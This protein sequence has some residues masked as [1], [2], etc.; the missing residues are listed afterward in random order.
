M[1]SETRNS[2]L[3]GI[4]ENAGIA[5]GIGIFLLITGVLALGAPLV[6]GISIMLMI[7]LLMIVGGVAQCILAFKVGAFGRGVLL[8]LMGVLMVVVGGYMLSQPVAALASMT[9]FLAA[10]FMVTGIVELFAAFGVRPAEGWGWVLVNGIV[11]LLL[12][13]MIW[14]QFPLS[15]VWAIGPLFGIKLLFSGS[16]LLGLGM[17]ARRGVK[18]IEAS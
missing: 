11:T 17:A 8:F 4:K 7:G 16:S 18:A 3:D 10:Y 15:G 12:G 14:R 6:T 2:F 5:I 1:V 13:L 9:L